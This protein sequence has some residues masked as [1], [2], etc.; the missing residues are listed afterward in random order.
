MLRRRQGRGEDGRGRRYKERWEGGGSKKCGRGG[1]QGE[2]VRGEG[3]YA[4]GGGKGRGGIY[5][6]RR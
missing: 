6:R 1:V 2:E 3:E 4:G 5:W